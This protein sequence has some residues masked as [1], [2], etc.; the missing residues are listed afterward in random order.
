MSINLAVC[1]F[2]DVGLVRETNEDALVIADL[3]GD[4][5]IGAIPKAGFEIR[6][7][8]VLLAVSDGMGGHNAGEVAS[9]LVVE[10]LKRAMKTAPWSASDEVLFERAVKSANR[11]VWEA[12]QLPDRKDMG[13]TLTAVFLHGPTAYIAEVGDSRA[14]L[15]RG[16]RLVQ[17]TRDQSFV[18]MLV[19]AGALTPEDAADAP[20]KNVILQAMGQ[21]PEVQVALGKIDL[22]QGDCFL[23]CSDGLTNEL[24]ASEI[25][26]AIL[27]A[28]RLE[29]A[30][31]T[32]IGLARARGGHDNITV[33]LGAVSGQ[34]PEVAPGERVSGAL[35]RL[36]E[37]DAPASSHAR[38]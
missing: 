16:G 6:E 23:L 21:E 30:G 11:L 28:P 15:L 5:F 7:R 9:A 36:K 12:A 37:F 29:A 31:T 24:G 8:G 35:E 33:V 17:V 32:L 38:P 14:Y 4:S 10:S 22:R 1:G 3:T 34:L 20:Y 19:D 18:Q 2:T 25:R 13:A 26:D 27:N